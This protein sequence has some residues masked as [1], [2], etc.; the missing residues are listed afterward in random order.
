MIK[1]NDIRELVAVCD[2]ERVFIDKRIQVKGRACM[3]LLPDF[4]LVVVYNMSEEDVALLRNKK[5]LKICT[6]ENAV[7]C[8]G[9]VEDIYSHYDGTNQI[10]E[11]SISDGQ[12]FWESRIN[13]TVGGGASF[14]TT[15][16]NILEGA[17][18]GSYLADDI[19]FV[20]GQTF[21]GR[22]AD[23]VLSIVKGVSARAFISDNVLHVVAKERSEIIVKIMEDDLVEDPNYANGV[24]I[25]KTGVKSWP[26]GMLHE[27]R[28]KR[29]RLVSKT[30]SADTFRGDW[31]VELILVDEDELD[32]DGMEGG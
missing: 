19:R 27:L 15:L 5:V 30:I 3:T 13:K 32:K 26:V 12:T 14:S 11:V 10:F 31:Q 23:A 1:L 21:V 8:S 9:E 29:Y 25:V 6:K 4:F 16:L 20:R 7:I 28:D 17:R 2:G 18:M 22:L 24:C